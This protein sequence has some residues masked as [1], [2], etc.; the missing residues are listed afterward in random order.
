MSWTF[1]RGA[2]SDRV[3]VT[4][5]GTPYMAVTRF[6]HVSDIAEFAH[7]FRVELL[8]LARIEAA[9]PWNRHPIVAPPQ[10]AL[11]KPVEISLDGE[12]VLRGWVDE[13]APDI[14]ESEVSLTLSGRDVT[15]DLVDCAAAPRGPHEYKNITLQALAEKLC[16]PFGVKVRT[17]CDTGQPFPRVSID[18]SETVHSVL[19]KYGRKRACLITSDGVGSV[20]ITRSGQTRAPGDIVFG[21]YKRSGGRFDGSRRFADVYVKGQAA[22]AGG[23]RGAAK[24]DVTAAPL[25]APA[26]SGGDADKPTGK[27][28]RAVAI[29][30]HARDPDVGRYRPMVRQTRASGSLQDAQTEADWYVRNARGAGAAVDYQ[31]ADWREAGTLW[32]PNQ[33]TTVRDPYQ[34]PPERELLI[35][36]VVN[37]WGEGGAVSRLRVTGRE[38]Y[39]PEPE[40][41]ESGGKGR[42]KA[43]ADTE[44]TDLDGEAK[45][46]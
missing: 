31:V 21:R 26:A 37:I 22:Y 17:E 16:Q 1:G 35:A 10:L 20:V 44:S 41:E 27:E 7:S 8:D 6:E 40:L 25:G 4:V 36:G 11:F 45:P 2:A 14:S 3:T 23:N 34:A 28:A 30:G 29:Q 15:G 33:M 39:D 19:E 32:R 43:K 42:A 5:D 9:L 38:A 13:V 12:L 24:L 18:A 46:L